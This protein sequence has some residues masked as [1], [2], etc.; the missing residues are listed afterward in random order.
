[1]APSAE[2]SPKVTLFSRSCQPGEV[3][4]LVVEGAQGKPEGKFL[5]ETLDFFPGSSG[6]WLSLAAIDL[7]VKPGKYPVEVSEAKS[8]LV[9]KE[10][11]D[12]AKKEFAERHLKVDKKFTAPTKKELERAEKETKEILAVFHERSN[13]RLF[14]KN[15]QSPISG[16]TASR[17]GERSF[18][19]DEAKSPH[20]GAD[21]KAD[22]GVIVRTAAEG[23]VVL[24][25]DFFFPGKTVIVDHGHGL[26]TAYMHLSEISVKVGDR[27]LRESVIGKV[28]A[29]GRVTGP[30]LH[31]AMKLYGK[32]VDPFS[33]VSLD[34]E[35]WLY[36]SA[37]PI[38]TAQAT[39]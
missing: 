34:L 9:W 24:I 12:V 35:K 27:L 22:A 30:H 8:K 11:V 4:L 10:D 3:F 36:P 32:R 25:G 20:S 18:F 1:M 19:N 13:E 21:L 14:Q 16:T 5:E 2:I 31:W 7:E 37:T 17:F 26:F 29:T 28:G 38:P 33:M 15:F 23:K 6:V 39:P